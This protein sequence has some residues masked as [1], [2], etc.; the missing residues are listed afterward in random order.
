MYVELPAH[1]L[2][3][4]RGDAIGAVESVKSASDILTPVSGTIVGVNEA[5]QESPGLINKDPEGEGGWIAKIDVG[6]QGRK[7]FER[8]DKE[9][10][11]GEGEDEGDPGL[12]SED[13]YG[14]FT[15]E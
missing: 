9:T 3:T 13:E 7:D 4:K 2:Q 11:Q 1:G 5:L 8:K 12:M 14:K 15:A 6:E 10:K